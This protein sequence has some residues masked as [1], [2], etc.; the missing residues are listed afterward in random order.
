MAYGSGTMVDVNKSILLVFAHPDDKS[1]SVAGTVAKYTHRRVTVDLICTTRGEKGTR[2]DVGDNMRTGTAREAEL[3]AAAGI[4]G[5]R[6]IY[7]LGYI[8]GE[9]GKASTDE[10]TGEVLAIIR[11]LQP[12]VT[13]FY[14]LDPALK[15][16]GYQIKSG[17]QGKSRCRK[18][19][20]HVLSYLN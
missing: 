11:S 17:C 3:R 18:Y 1:F 13:A 2:L 20:F 10:V 6:D 4:I 8:D 9:L 15:E 5:I 12:E 16:S 7:F 19:C 14:R